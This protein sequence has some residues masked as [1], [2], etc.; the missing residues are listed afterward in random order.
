MHDLA[1]IIYT[2]RA[3]DRSRPS[4]GDTVPY[5]AIAL[6]IPM[7]RRDDRAAVSY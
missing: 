6:I 2:L 7:V 5:F 4:I 1:D 3:D